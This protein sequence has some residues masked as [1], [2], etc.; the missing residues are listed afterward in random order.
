MLEKESFLDSETVQ[1]SE[2]EI[3]EE[4][5][6]AKLRALHLLTAMDRTEAQL[7]EKLEVSYCEQA[8]EEAVAYVKNYGYLDDERYVKVYIESK[9]R[10]KSRKQ[11]EQDLIYKKGVSKEAVYRGFEQAQMADVVEVIQKYMQKKKIDPQTCDY[12]QKQKF[13]AYMMRKGFQIEEL[14]MVFGLT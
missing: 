11:I 4:V 3:K 8:V 14:K 5:R 10:T 9:S 2:E 12:E 1:K 7:R 6:R 13:F